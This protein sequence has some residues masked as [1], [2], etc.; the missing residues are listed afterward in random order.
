MTFVF[1]S[2][3]RLALRI[4]IALGLVVRLAIFWHTPSLGTEIQDE[5]HYVQLA[6]NITAG[7][8]FAWAAGQ[9]TSIRPPLFPALVA[10]V[11][12]IAGTGNL[13]A[14]R[15]VQII[16][17]LLTV[18]V[19][20]DLGRRTFS[21]AAGRYA[22]AI[23]FLYPSSV[24]FNFTILTETLFTLLLL[25]FVLLAVI[26][27]Q[28]PRVL[29]AVACGLTLGLGALTRSVLWPLPLVLC[30]LLALLIRGSIARRL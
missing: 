11:F 17:A 3:G 5:R 21:A 12:S 30:P 9:P 13:Q 1:S 7:N 27:V 10:A 26:L 22:A 4:A 6:E 8:G 25:T 15:A 23:F 19:I 18:A 14:V 29:V 28:T 24:F 16:L 2:D 20:C